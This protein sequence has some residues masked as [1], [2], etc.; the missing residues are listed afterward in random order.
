MT[1]H[2]SVQIYRII[3]STVLVKSAWKQWFKNW[4]TGTIKSRDSYVNTAHICISM[5]YEHWLRSCD[6]LRLFTGVYKVWFGYHHDNRLTTT[7]PMNYY[8][9]LSYCARQNWYSIV[10]Y[11]IGLVLNAILIQFNGWA[12]IGCSKTSL[13][14]AA[15]K[16]LQ[17]K[18]K[19]Y[20]SCM[21]NCKPKWDAIIWRRHSLNMIFDISHYC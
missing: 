12:W 10:L 18:K 13:Q 11:S 16:I 3:P 20:I 15:Y 8:N 19:K 1:A 2:R 17:Q 6:G 9:S 7:T 5:P 14:Y 4:K 21:I